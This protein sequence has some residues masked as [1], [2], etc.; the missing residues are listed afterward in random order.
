MP[1]VSVILQQDDFP[2]N[3]FLDQALYGWVGLREKEWK[4]I[5]YQKEIH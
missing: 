3:Y 5:T 4:I 2:I 1:Y